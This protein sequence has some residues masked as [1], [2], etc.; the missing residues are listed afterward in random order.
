MNT[1]AMQV[2]LIEQHDGLLWA[3]GDRA[4]HDYYE[5]Q[6][7]VREKRMLQPKETST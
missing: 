5:L 1:A 7:S 2:H 6:E 4:D 3:E